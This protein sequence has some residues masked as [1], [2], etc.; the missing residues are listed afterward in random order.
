MK[1]I[2]KLTESDL[3]KIVKRIINESQDPLSQ[4]TKEELDNIYDRVGRLSQPGFFEDDEAES[5]L[6]YTVAKKDENLYGSLVDWLEKNGIYNPRLRQGHRLKT[7]NESQDPLSQFTEE[8][9]EKIYK[10]V[11]NMSNPVFFEDWEARNY[12]YYKVANKD[13]ELFDSLVQWMNGKGFDTR[14][15]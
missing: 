3:T 7:V 14:N 6:F 12:L 5:Y 4:F 15:L 2:I 11:L 1:K 9:L 8:E 13:E 10:E